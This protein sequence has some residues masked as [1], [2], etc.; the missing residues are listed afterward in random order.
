MSG[1]PMVGLMVT[2][3]Q[4]EA[5]ATDRGFWPP[6]TQ[7]ETFSQHLASNQ[8]PQ[9]AVVGWQSTFRTALHI[10][11]QT[12]FESAAKQWSDE[13]AGHSSMTARKRHPAYQKLVSL[14]WDAVPFLL[15]ALQVSP[16]Y[17]FPILHEITG[18]NPVHPNDRG[19]YNKMRDAWLSWGRD[20]GLIS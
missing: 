18:E 13:T 9:A 5:R 10:N 15:K 1:S 17:W 12:Q 4:V 11:A 14:R 20:R 3:S 16:D 6:I 8:V 19:D 7:R 2:T